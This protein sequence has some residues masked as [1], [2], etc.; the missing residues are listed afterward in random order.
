MTKLLNVA[1]CGLLIFAATD[2][3]NAQNHAPN[4][5]KSI[6]GWAELPDGRKWGSTSAIYPANDGKHIWIAERC[7][8]NL[9][10][11]S[12]VDPVLLFDPDGN[13]VKSFGAGLITWPHGIF[14]DA[15]DNVW[16]ADAVGYEPVTE[17]VGHTV[18]KFSPDGELLMRLGKEGISGDGT[19]VFTKP[20]DVFVAPNGNIF[21]A[22]GHDAGG[23]N[24]IVKFDKD[25]NYL[26][27]WGSTGS[28]NGEFRDP[29]ALAMDSQGRLFVADRTNRRIQI[30]TQNGEWIATWT[31]FSGPSGLYIDAND[32]L[33]SA[34]SESNERRNT[35]W[36]RGIRIGSAKDGFV[37]EFIP[38][39]EPD[40]DNSG[41]SG[42]E[43]IALDAEGNIYGAEVG[44]MA[45][46]KYVRKK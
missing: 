27:Q 37:T 6:S 43:G 21:V 31:Q 15:D 2:S 33:Y 45:V 24:R 29:H 4:P 39:P 5:Y 19:D 26:M 12:N 1:M 16:I 30:F 28:E 44:P 13:V 18:M 46:M 42:A 10:V 41:T 3:V 8:T 9:C 23:N 7:G 34:D 32:I 38:D 36:K 11:G 35:G 22:D 20:S 14:V 40:Q 17:G 25:G